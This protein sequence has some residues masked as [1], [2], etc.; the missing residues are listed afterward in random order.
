MNAIDIENLS[1]SYNG[2]PVL[3]K[4][5]FHVKEGEFVGLIGPNGGGKTTL[6]KLMLGLL[7]PEQGSILIFGRKPGDSRELVGYVPQYFAF[8]RSFPITVE[9]VVRMGLIRPGHWSFRYTAEER[10]IVEQSLQE[11]GITHL[12]TRPIGQLSGGQQQR[13][14]V[15]RALA[16]RPRLL[17]LDEP[18]ANID[19][20]GEEDI[21]H[22]L[23]RLNQRMTIV[24][25][26]HDIGFIS[27]YVT[28]VACLNRTLMLHEAT[29]LD[30]SAVDQLYNA[31]VHMIEHDH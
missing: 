12:S 21:F 9:Q 25:V 8:D 26:S 17:L 24:V 15:A 1:F 14:L 3:E 30:G 2:V 22:L 16:G 19:Q 7:K 11:T 18:T 6:L 5:D 28:T 27:E 31:H 20:R 29:C 13:V 10:Q 23:K 4:L